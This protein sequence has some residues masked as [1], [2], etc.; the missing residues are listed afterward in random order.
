ML[1]AVPDPTTTLDDAEY[2]T[3]PVNVFDVE[4]LM[5][6]SSSAMLP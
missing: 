6:K 1:N 2:V 5:I 3:V 4:L